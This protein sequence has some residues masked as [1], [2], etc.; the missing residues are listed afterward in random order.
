MK[1]LGTLAFGF[2]TIAAM[3]AA[4]LSFGFQVKVES[5]VSPTQIA[6]EAQLNQ[7]TAALG[8][9]EQQMAAARTRV[10]GLEARL[11]ESALI[12]EQSASQ[13]SAAIAQRAQMSREGSLFAGGTTSVAAGIGAGLL[14]FPLGFV[15][16]RRRT[17]GPPILAA[18]VQEAVIVEP[19]REPLH[20]LPLFTAGRATP[21]VRSGGPHAHTGTVR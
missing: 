17:A 8:Q 20:S 16:G 9:A 10:Q 5:P 11:A 14:M 4:L 15:F 7:C 18:R 13:L 1:F 19:P 21:H 12:A 2:S 3:I 6:K